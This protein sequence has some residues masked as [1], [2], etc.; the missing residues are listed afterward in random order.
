MLQPAIQRVAAMRRQYD[1]TS[2]FAAMK[3]PPSAAASR[4]QVGGGEQRH[5]PSSSR[6]AGVV[7]TR[8][9]KSAR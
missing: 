2:V 4:T 5:T 7:C 8:G 9:G 1:P 6:Q 3:R